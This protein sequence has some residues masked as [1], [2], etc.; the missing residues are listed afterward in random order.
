MFRRALLKS[1]TR[2]GPAARIPMPPAFDT[3]I[4][5]GAL[6]EAQLM[7]AWKIGSS[8]PSSSVILVFNGWSSFGRLLPVDEVARAERELGQRLVEHAPLLRRQ[9]ATERFVA[10]GRRS[11]QPHVKLAAGFAEAETDAAAV[12]RV[13]LAQHDPTRREPGHD[14]A[15]LALVDAGSARELVQRQRLGG[16]AEQCDAAPFPQAHAEL[17]PVAQLGAARQ[18]VRDGMQ[19]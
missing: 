19:P 1:S 6:E 11:D 16:G 7:A 17:A 3:A 4:T 8:M 14:A 15:H 10:L 9:A 2:M 18:Q 5:S 13:G 12:D